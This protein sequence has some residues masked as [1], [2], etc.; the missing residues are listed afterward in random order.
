[1][2]RSDSRTAIGAVTQLLQGHLVLDG[3]DVS[4]GRPEDASKSGTLDKLNLFLYEAEFDPQMR[5]LS[6]R[7]G[8][9]PPL[10][11]VLKYL[12][13]AFDSKHNSDTIG[14]H[15]VLGSGIAALQAL[16]FLSLPASVSPVRLALEHNPEPL[17]LT[18]DD[19]KADLLSRIMQGTDE[20]YRLSAAFQV[21]PVMIVPRSLQHG[22]QLVGV[23]YRTAPETIIGPEGVQIE[24][25]ISPGPRLRRLE[26]LRLE[27]GG[28]VTLTGEALGGGDLEVVL[29]DVPLQVVSRAPA[30]IVATVEGSPGTPIASGGTLSAG[31][32]ALAVRRRVS[33]Q[34]TRTS[35]LLIA[36]LAPTLSSAAIAGGALQ[37]NGLLLGATGDDIVVLA[38][39]S[40]DGATVHVF[41]EVTTA[42]NQQS[43]L[44]P[45]AATA[46]GPGTYRIILR[47]NDQQATASPS[48]TI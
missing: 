12:L 27:A 32:L 10:W 17:K 35:N 13:T 6:V 34:R 4:I 8:E 1:M 24:V 14:A 33:P 7:E 2:A 31:E 38:C 5:N 23:D 39:R 48:V 20:K 3:F 45:D 42:S 15:E 46:L 47:V 25:L 26:P 19:A 41:D 9:P 22:S 40:T 43:L 30:R 28:T 44:V 11:L 29:G 18:F 21:R 37:L 36:R 16:S